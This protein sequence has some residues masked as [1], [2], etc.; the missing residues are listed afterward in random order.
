MPEEVY[1]LIIIGGGP[2]GLAAGIYAARSRLKVLLLE[3]LYTGGQMA[4]TD[5]IENY[6]GFEESISGFDLTQKME[7]QAKR[8]GLPIKN[9]E[10]QGV[11]DYD[12]TVKTL[13]T[14]EGQFFTKTLVIGTGA[15]PRKLGV[16]G[17]IELS[18]KGVSYCAVCDGAFYRGKPVV[19]VG[20]GDSAVEEAEYLTR[21]ASSVSVVHRR[22]ELRA[23]Q[24][25][26]D[27]YLS[28]DNASVIWDSVVTRIVGEEFVTGVEVKNVKTGELSITE[29][30]GVFMYVGIT[31]RSELF[32]EILDLDEAGFI[33]VDRDMATNAPGIFAIGDVRAGSVRQIATAVGDG[34]SAEQYCER[35]LNQL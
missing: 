6:P 8:M 29:C 28:H 24:K 11:G 9:I 2:G 26:Q 30:E 10:L 20:G 21:F 3:K 18:G 35:Y 32:K 4:Q 31:P 19:V 25:A 15:N 16:P 34:V 33:K 5:A 7:K 13:F 23:N 17:E 27:D 12:Q 22:D 1:D 14:S